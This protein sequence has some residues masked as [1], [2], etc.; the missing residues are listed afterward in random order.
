LEERTVPS[1]ASPPT[2]TSRTYEVNL[3]AANGGIEAVHTILAVSDDDAI[4][5]TAA[6]P[7][8]GTIEIWRDQELVWRFDPLAPKIW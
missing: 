3:I 5:Q 4:E 8:T 1:E 6:E 7:Y 2:N